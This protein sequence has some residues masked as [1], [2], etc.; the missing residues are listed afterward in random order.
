MQA[1]A[2]SS[3]GQRE[4]LTERIADGMLDFVYA[5]PQGGGV[6]MSGRLPTSTPF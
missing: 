3:G 1:C 2:P 4:W 5:F 6:A